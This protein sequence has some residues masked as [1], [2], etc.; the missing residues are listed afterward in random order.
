MRDSSVQWMYNG[1]DFPVQDAELRK[2]NWFEAANVCDGG[3]EEK[4]LCNIRVHS[5]T[6]YL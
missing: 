2:F 1:G 3:R 5:P 4:N 6:L